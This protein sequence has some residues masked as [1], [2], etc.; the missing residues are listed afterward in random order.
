MK[1]V[2]PVYAMFLYPDNGFSWDVEM[3][4][5]LDYLTVYPVDEIKITENYSWIK[6]FGYPDWFNAVQFQY[7]NEDHK[8]IDIYEMPE[9]NPYLS[10]KER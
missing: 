5:K 10:K 1:T 2:E 9:Y 8:I 4:K 7:Y 3:A 6:L